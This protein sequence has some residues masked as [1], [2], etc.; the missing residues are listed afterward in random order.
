M[1]F[2][3]F[4]NRHKRI[5]DT[6]RSHTLTQNVQNIIEVEEFQ[7]IYRHYP[8]AET[9]KRFQVSVCHLSSHVQ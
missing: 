6:C 5:S 1:I 2:S 9:F 4:M 7:I 8:S 3:I